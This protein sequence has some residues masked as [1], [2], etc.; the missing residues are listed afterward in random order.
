V[1]DTDKRLVIWNDK[2]R[3]K[4]IL[5]RYYESIGT[6][7]CSKI[8]TVA[9]DGAQTYISSTNKYAVNAMIV[10][11]RFHLIQK[12]NNTVDAVRKIELNKA[13][14]NKD[15]ELIDMMNCKQRFILLKS[16]NNLTENQAS[17]LEEL[18]SVNKPIFKAIL[19]K[20]TFLEIYSIG[21]DNKVIDQHLE[22]WL[23]EAKESNLNPFITL[24]EK[25]KEKKQYILNWFIQ[26]TSSAISERFNNK[27]KRLKRM[28]YGYKDIY[29]FRL[30]IHQHCGLLNPRLA[31]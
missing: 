16:K 8:K 21:N 15:Q 20:E 12:L 14:E 31:T 17:R 1:I 13:R 7:N 25:L 10:Y 6:V 4:E 29:Y 27:I 2:G 5:N 19:L 22:D 18:C 26:K 24:A 11:D 28:A 9:L 30:K 23:K 3:K